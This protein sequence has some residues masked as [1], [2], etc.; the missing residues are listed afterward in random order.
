MFGDAEITP[1]SRPHPSPPRPPSRDRLTPPPKSRLA[2][3]QSCAPPA[4]PRRRTPSFRKPRRASAP[5]LSHRDGVAPPRQPRADPH[6]QAWSSGLLRDFHRLVDQ[7]LRALG[8]AAC[9]DTNGAPHASSPDGGAA[10]E[11][12][13]R[14]SG[15]EEAWGKD[16]KPEGRPVRRASAQAMGTTQSNE[17]GSAWVGDVKTYTLPRTGGNRSVSVSGA[18]GVVYRTSTGH[19]DA[20]DPGCRLLRVNPRLSRSHSL[21]EV[22]PLSPWALHHLSLIDAAH[23][24]PMPT[25]TSDKANKSSTMGAAR[26]E[27]PP[28]A[29]ATPIS[30]S[31]RPGIIRKTGRPE[32]FNEQ[33]RPPTNGWP[34]PPISPVGPPP[35]SPAIPIVSSRM[36]A[37]TPEDLQKGASESWAWADQEDAC[38]LTDR[39][40]DSV[41]CVHCQ[42]KC[43]NQRPA[44]PRLEVQPPHHP[45]DSLSDD[46]TEAT[47]ERHR[48][49]RRSEPALAGTVALEPLDSRRHTLPVPRGGSRLPVPPPVFTASSWETLP[50]A[51]EL[52]V[53]LEEKTII[54]ALSLPPIPS[55][56]P[57]PH[58]PTSSHSLNSSLSSL[59]HISVHR[60]HSECDS[61][62]SSPAADPVRC[63]ELSFLPG[64]TPSP[65][66]PVQPSPLP[67]PNCGASRTSQSIAVPEPPPPI[68]GTLHVAPPTSQGTAGEIVFSVT[69]P[70]GP[71][72]PS[73]TSHMR[74]SDVRRDDNS[75]ADHAH[76][77]PDG[78]PDVSWTPAA[79]HLTVNGLDDTSFPVEEWRPPPPRRPA[80]PT[81]QRSFSLD[82]S[83]APSRS[84]PCT[85]HT[86]VK[87]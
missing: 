33:W 34:E 45:D 71:T 17:Q 46:P 68:T 53:E 6:L 44:P 26:P 14:E 28:S 11:E 15:G 37:F 36:S 82:E 10:S 85:E 67:S 55:A 21:D 13:E 78:V 61:W 18:A 29:P 23:V 43:V 12:E 2:R 4:P 59:S 84:R 40:C 32:M 79:E 39:P 80:P 73:D 54:E 62:P 52:E 57:A 24:R 77:S 16:E 47:E 41:E 76:A 75:G 19:P 72:T 50:P 70:P 86:Q 87:V 8:G 22:C 66:S 20:P 27:A 35:P 9:E 3:R 64:F 38:I 1:C 83:H 5:A 58:S 63:T 60:D 31:V 7:E 30:G 81:R 69:I 48:Q 56:P 49:E 42:A 74:A 65:V 51:D 25:I